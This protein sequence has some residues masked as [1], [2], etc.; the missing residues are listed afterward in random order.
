MSL[1]SNL[2]ESQCLF[3]PQVEVKYAQSMLAELGVVE[4]KGINICKLLS[5]SQDFGNVANIRFQTI[6]RDVEDE[7]L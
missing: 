5:N 7:I 4:G 1:H 6:L 3:F 2:W